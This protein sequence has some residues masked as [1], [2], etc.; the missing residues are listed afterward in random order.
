MKLEVFSAV[1]MKIAV[2]LNVTPSSRTTI[3]NLFGE[4]AASFF[5]V[6]NEKG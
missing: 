5:T 1:T 2:F 4:K 3:Y 6:E